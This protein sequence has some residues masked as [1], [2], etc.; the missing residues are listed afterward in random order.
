VGSALT[1]CLLC[2]LE[3]GLKLLQ[4]QLLNPLCMRLQVLMNSRRGGKGVLAVW[5]GDQSRPEAR[6]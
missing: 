6:S 1:P 4:P 5:I 2:S 3:L